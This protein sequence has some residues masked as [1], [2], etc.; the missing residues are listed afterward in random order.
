MTK[1]KGIDFADQV[2]RKNSSPAG[3]APGAA[4]AIAPQ[5]STALAPTGASDG[6]ARTE[7][8][9]LISSST[10]WETSDWWEATCAKNALARFRPRGE[11][12][13]KKSC[14]PLRAAEV[15]RARRCRARARRNLRLC[16]V[17]RF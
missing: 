6:T 3:L 15:P 1:A 7:Q 11:P 4:E 8:E 10:G 14:V 9:M 16:R 17:G 5:H 2:N 13:E 12:G